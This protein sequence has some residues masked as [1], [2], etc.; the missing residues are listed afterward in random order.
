MRKNGL[1]DIYSYIN[2]FEVKEEDNTHIKGTKQID[3]VMTTTNLLEVVQG[4]RMVDS[5]EITD[6]DHRGFIVDINVKEYFFIEHS[7]C[8]YANNA[9]LDSTKRSHR[10]KFQVKLDEYIE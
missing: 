7:K 4:S 10:Q 5:K 8:E 9:T 1:F 3:A 6:S 2:N